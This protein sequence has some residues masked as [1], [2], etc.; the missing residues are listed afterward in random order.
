MLTPYFLIGEVLKPHGVRG[1][2]K[3]KP[4]A[5]DPGDFMRWKTLY[6]KESGGWRPVGARC[7]RVHDGFAYVTL[8]G[9]A[10]P[11]DV[12]KVRGL[13]LYIDRAHAAPLPEGM[14]YISDLLGC[15]AEDEN[16]KKVG[17]LTDVLQ[18]GP[19][20]V[21]VFRTPSGG[22]MMAPNLPDVFTEKDVAAGRIRVCAARLQEVAVYDED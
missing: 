8:E 16:G 6:V 19:V 13:E 17:T 5:Q 4:Y 14:F 1:E 3:V 2:A 22:T 21:W 15:E 18:H 7:S 20:D 12:E 9:C 11:E 10:S